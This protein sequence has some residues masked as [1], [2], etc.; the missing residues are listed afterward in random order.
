MLIIAQQ[1]NLRNQQPHGGKRPSFTSELPSVF[2]ILIFRYASST[3]FACI[4]ILRFVFSILAGYLRNLF[5][6]FV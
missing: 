2:T 6:L 1:F 5:G 4:I 3:P